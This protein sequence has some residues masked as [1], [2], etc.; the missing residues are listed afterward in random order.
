MFIVQLLDLQNTQVARTGS[1]GENVGVKDIDKRILHTL[2]HKIHLK[3][4]TSHFKICKIHSLPGLGQMG[5]KNLVLIKRA[6]CSQVLCSTRYNYLIT[7]FQ[8]K[9][10]MNI[11]FCC[12]KYLYSDTETTHYLK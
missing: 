5:K 11:R 4:I 12:A 7:A 2:F 1:N 10:I 8:L 9:E 6:V 3:Q